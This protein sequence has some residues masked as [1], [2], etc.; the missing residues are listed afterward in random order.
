MK[1]IRIETSR[2]SLRPLKESDVAGLHRIWT[3]PGVRKFLWDD[4]EISA[5]ET[6]EVVAG[7]VAIF[8]EGG[9]GLW[10]VSWR[11][12]A[13]LIGFC[14]Y[15]HFHD[16]PELQ[17]LYGIEVGHWGQGLATET[18]KAMIRYGFEN[19]SYEQVIASTDAPNLASLRVME[20]AGMKYQKRVNKNG[21]DT[22]CYI[23]RRDEWRPDDSYFAVL[24][25]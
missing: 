22:I 20:K 16:P 8:Q 21:L 7:S 18:A 9:P 24:E 5:T 4:R 10:A 23:A 17:L 11:R 12:A 2:L 3:D 15:W 25:G 19:M 1:D 14:G 13:G 6:A